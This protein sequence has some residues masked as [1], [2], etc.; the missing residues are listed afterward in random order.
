M[1]KLVILAASALCFG[2]AVVLA[3]TSSEIVGAQAPYEAQMVAIG[4]HH[5]YVVCAVQFSGR[6]AACSRSRGVVFVFVLAYN[7]SLTRQVPERYTL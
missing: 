2:T 7:P 3:Q 4:D 1:L 6:C 5:L